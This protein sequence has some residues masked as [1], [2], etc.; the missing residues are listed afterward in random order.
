[1]ISGFY[2][3]RK[4]GKRYGVI[5]C[6]PLVLKGIERT[7]SNPDIFHSFNENLFLNFVILMILKLHVGV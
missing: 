1:M 4:T 5:Q 3:S 6:D 7:V 2:F